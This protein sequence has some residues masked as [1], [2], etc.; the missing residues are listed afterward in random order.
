MEQ[1]IKRQVQERYFEAGEKEDDFTPYPPCTVWPE[2]R[3][4]DV[5]EGL[6]RFAC[7]VAV[8]HTVYGQSFESLTTEHILGLVSQLRPDMVKQLKTAGSG[9]LP[10]DIQQR[11]ETPMKLYEYWLGLYPLDWEF[12]FMPVQTYKNFITEQYHKNPAFYNISAGSIE[13][14][15]T[16]IDAI[17][18]AAM[19]DWNKTTNHAALR[20]PPMIFPF[21]K[22]QESN[23]AEFAVILKMDND[24]DT[25]VY[26]PIPL[27]HLENQ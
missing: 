10:K 2:L 11:K 18:S 5:D 6:L 23:I 9:K 26:S 25:V 24:G 13:K 15:L 8:C 4:E 22:G 16:H 3:P 20:C 14:V 1:Y 21:P 27:P 17:L 7:H 12:C 19:E